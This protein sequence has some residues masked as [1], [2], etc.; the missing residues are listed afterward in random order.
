MK[1]SKAMKEIHEIREKLY[2]ER[3]GLSDKE[4]LNEI[5]KSSEEV[6]KKYNLKLRR[7]EKKIN[8]AHKMKQLPV[9]CVL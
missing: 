9:E 6:I 1:E 2:E 8:V 4:F 7:E 5:H 3:K